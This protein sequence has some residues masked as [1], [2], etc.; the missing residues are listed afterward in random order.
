MNVDKHEIMW[1]FIFNEPWKL[2]W[3]LPIN[4]H[5]TEQ[6]FKQKLRILLLNQTICHLEAELYTVHRVP[7]LYFHCSGSTDYNLLN[8]CSVQ[9]VLPPHLCLRGLWW[10]AGDSYSGHSAR[11]GRWEYSEGAGLHYTEDGAAKLTWL[12]QQVISAGAW[13]EMS[14]PGQSRLLA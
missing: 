9:G 14:H 5:E 11:A 7:S 3:K 4:I 2:C 1:K 12:T 10:A 8:I 6:I 13:C